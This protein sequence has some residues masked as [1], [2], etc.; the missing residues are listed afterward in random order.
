MEDNNEE[1]VQNDVENT[2]E[3]TL[4]EVVVNASQDEPE[5]EE[6]QEEQKNDDIEKQIEERA[7]KMFEEKVE[8]RLK[9]DRQSRERRQEQEM[10]KYKQ[11]ENV[12]KTGLGVDTIDDAISKTSEFYREQGINIPEYK[13][14]YSERREKNL[15]KLEAQEIIELGYDDMVS[16]ANRLSSI[17]NRSPYEET[18]FMT[19]CEK[20]TDMKNTK[21]LQ[22]KG[23]DTAILKDEEFNKFKNRFIN[24]PIT[25]IYDMYS[26]LNAKPPVVKP[27][28]AGSAKTETNNSSDT[29]TAEQIN[30]MKPEEMLKYWNNPAFR[31]LAGLN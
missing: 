22:D 27:A 7:N 26:K 14:E 5:Q 19:L 17:S 21:E 12:I 29:F 15:A 6:V 23:I 11:L 24:T 18:M 13:D 8:E 30:N 31:K 25:E 4:D 16:E 10:A 28:S 9:R 3:E 2:S 20:L 1:V